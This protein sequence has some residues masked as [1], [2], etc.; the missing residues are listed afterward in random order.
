MRATAAVATPHPAAAAAGRT[1][2]L[3]GGN[4]V[5]AA[6]GAMLACC[7]ATPGMVG[8]GGYGGSLVAFLA[9]KK[10][11]VAIDFDSRAPLAYRPEAFADAAA[12]ETGY[13]SITVPAVVAGLDL[14]LTQFGTLPWAVVSEP[15][16]ALA[17]GG[18][19]VSAELKRTLDSWWAKADSVSRRALFP[20]GSIPDVGAA[21]VQRDMAG[22][23]RRLAADGPAAFYRGDLPRA[24]VRQVRDHGGLLAEEDFARY[25][26]VIVEPLAITYR[27]HRV[28]TPPPPS[29]GLTSLQMLR[30]LEQFDLSRLRPWGGEYL[31]LVA[32]AAKLAWRDRAATLGDPDVTLIPVDRLLS[33]EAARAN[34]AAVVSGVASAPRVGLT[35]PS[36]QHTVNVVAADA[37]GN[38]VSMTA[39]NGYLYGSAVV[40]DGL[41]L[42]MNHGMS[43]FD[44]ARGSPNAPSPGKRMIHNMAPTIFLGPDGKARGAVGLPGGPKIVTV[45]AQLMVS[46][47]D[48]GTTPPAAAVT[49]GRIHAEADEPV[50]VS[51]SV[52]DGVVEELRA[53]GHTVRRGQ[54]VGGPPNEIGGMANALVIDPDTG[55]VSAA[56][57]AGDGTAVTVFV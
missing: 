37:A 14:A 38:V 43:R 31:H 1:I 49:A 36:P 44:R 19:P 18:V 55:A 47:V 10:A 21:W 32:E 50:A 27:G 11:T 16:I 45:T 15:A 4:A 3:R 35:G 13:L 12:Y 9:D 26:P 56:S 57:Q 2:L 48:F 34:A 20:S 30:T 53:L 23:L 51:S 54:D 46:L 24:I 40:I 39:T 28:L 42:V 29:G 25:Q 5:D 22:L 33:D 52:P 7:V 8:L 17:E 41:G 6:V